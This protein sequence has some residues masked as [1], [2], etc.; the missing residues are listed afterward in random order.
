MKKTKVLGL[1]VLVLAA[2]GT[3]AISSGTALKNISAQI[4]T[5]QGNSQVSF[6]YETEPVSTSTA[7]EAKELLNSFNLYSEYTTELDLL[8]K[9]SHLLKFNSAD[10][11]IPYM[12]EIMSYMERINMNPELDSQFFDLLPL[13]PEYNVATYGNVLAYLFPEEK[14]PLLFAV[15]KGLV[16]SD[17]KPNEFM[18]RKGFVELLGKVFIAT[19]EDPLEVFTDLGFIQSPELWSMETTNGFLVVD[20]IRLI[21]NVRELIERKQ[22]T[23]SK[24]SYE[25]KLVDLPQTSLELNEKSIEVILQSLQLERKDERKVTR[26]I[27]EA[28]VSQFRSEFGKTLTADHI[29]KI[30]VAYYQRMPRSQAM[31]EVYELPETQFVGD[32]ANELFRKTYMGSFVKTGQNGAMISCDSVIIQIPRNTYILNLFSLPKVSVYE[33]FKEGS[34][35]LRSDALKSFENT[36]IVGPEGEELVRVTYHPLQGQNLSG[37][38]FGYAVSDENNRQILS[39]VQKYTENGAELKIHLRTF[40]GDNYVYFDTKL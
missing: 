1:S 22:I 34:L 15:E 20:G 25:R 32:C 38:T 24:K 40:T 23:D 33:S 11:V 26:K 8:M 37:E 27:R 16:T 14:N 6:L 31:L 7:P 9:Y 2:L 18:S 4:L 29:E 30:R 36:L 28:V 12:N 3:V 17:A 13:W 19:N 21:L 35:V 10:K 5:I 39:G